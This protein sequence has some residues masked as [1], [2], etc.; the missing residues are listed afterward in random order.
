MGLEVEIARDDNFKMSKAYENNLSTDIKQSKGIYYTPKFIVKYILEN[1]LKYHDILKN[2]SPKVLDISCGCGNFLLEAY[3]ILYEII[4]KNLFE[5]SNLYGSDYWNINNIHNHIV[6]NCIYGADID[7]SAIEILKIS[8]KNKRGDYNIQKFNL[9]CCDSLRYEWNEKFDYIIGNPPYVGQKK[10]NNDYK[11]EI[12]K[13]YSEVYKDKS[14]IYYCFY[15]KII[16]ML[17][18]DGIGSIITPRYFLES[19]SGKYLRSYISKNINIKEIIDFLG[20]SIFKNIGICSCIS[21]FKKESIDENIEFFKIKN[22]NFELNND[23]NLNKL[24]RSDLFE[25]IIINQ[26]DLN[27]E[28]LIVNEQDKQFLKKIHKK[29]NYRLD[30]IAISFQGIISGCDKAFIIDNQNELV[31]K[32]D[33]SILKSWIKNKHISKYIIEDSNKNLI[34]SNDIKDEEEY[35]FEITEIIGKYKD[36]LANRRECKKNIRKWYELQWGREKSLFEQ[37]KIMYP[38]KCKEN[39][40]AIDYN[41]N[42]C[43]AD[44]YSFYI[45]DEY[46]NDFSYEYLVGILNS[47]IYEKYFKLIGKKISKNIYD[48]YPNKVMK[49]KIFKDEN[50]EK[51]EFLSRKMI[52]VLQGNEKNNEVINSLQYEIDKLVKLSLSI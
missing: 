36:K 4:E 29:C 47:C 23:M 44:I 11:K 21:T 24:V 20:C 30:D 52:K 10:L 46:K 33:K 16:Q 22:E 27:E 26:Q 37:V 41:Y 32:I 2:P 39:R 25:K 43:S 35:I 18:E 5:L 14:D 45:K 15:K 40:F 13:S 7:S 49:I 8:L 50:Y 3:D 38:Y 48:Y 12:M 28:W 31:D 19:P 6:T 17:D 9:Y 1:T 42:Y 34:Y 51:I